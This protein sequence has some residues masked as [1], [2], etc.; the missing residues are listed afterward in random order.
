MQIIRY[1]HQKSLVIV[2]NCIFSQIGFWFKS[3]QM[4]M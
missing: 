1:G 4:L 2:E 3:I